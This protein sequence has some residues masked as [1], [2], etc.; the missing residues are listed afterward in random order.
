M[1]EPIEKVRSLDSLCPLCWNKLYE[2]WCTP[3][4]DH[5]ELWLWFTECTKCDYSEEY[6]DYFNR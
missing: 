6:W 5:P 4:S 1:T 2:F 3:A